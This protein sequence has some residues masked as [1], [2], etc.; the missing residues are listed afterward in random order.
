MLAAM[1]LTIASDPVP[2]RVDE[3]GA[4]RVGGTQLPLQ[5]FLI[6]HLGGADA[7]ALHER[8]PRLALAD[9]HAV[10]A[11]YYR[12]R[13]EVDAWLAD[14]EAEADALQQKIESDPRNIALR[15]S[16]LRSRKELGLD[17]DA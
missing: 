3:S 10:L 7:Q 4:V 11:Y 14:C 8:F 6:E 2:L 13:P 12:Y 1:T 9:I 5:M 15:E 16:L 17:P